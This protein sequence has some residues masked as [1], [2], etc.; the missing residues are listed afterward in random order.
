MSANGKEVHA[1][2]GDGGEVRTI[3]EIS[4]PF[5]RSAEPRQLITVVKVV[6]THKI[7]PP[8]SYLPLLVLSVSASRSDLPFSTTGSSLACT[9]TIADLHS[10]PHAYCT[11]YNSVHM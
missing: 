3:K 9:H 6:G 1:L 7:Q 8:S 2:A 10:Y 5:K 11:V 4:L